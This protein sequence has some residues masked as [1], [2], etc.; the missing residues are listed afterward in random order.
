M[1]RLFFL[2][3]AALCA[4]LAAGGCSEGIK[5]TSLFSDM[6]S[7]ALTENSD[8][9]ISLNAEIEYPEAGSTAEGLKE[10]Q[11][12]IKKAVYG[13]KYSYL[14]LEDGFDTY[15]NDLLAEYRESSLP[16]LEQFGNEASLDWTYDIEARFSGE[17]GSMVSYTVSTYVYQG[18][19]HGLQT[20]RAYTFDLRSGKS[21]GED[22]IFKSGSEEELSKL[23]TDHAGDSFENPDNL[24]LFVSKVEPNDNFSIGPDGVTFFYNPYE[25]APYSSGIIPVTLSWSDLDGLL[26]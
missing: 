9:S 20:T 2:S 7:E 1:K 3:A 16:V 8:K 10:I 19:A 21:L 17:Y 25:I 14:G 18:G 24:T 6:R 5:S 12:Q 22:D 11:K 4:M 23:L 13:E 15:F 26:K